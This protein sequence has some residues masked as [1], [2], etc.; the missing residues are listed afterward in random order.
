M[1]NA[2]KYIFYIYLEHELPNICGYKPTRAAF[3]RGRDAG[4]KQKSVGSGSIR[5]VS[6]PL[7]RRS[8]TIP[9]EVI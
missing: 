2:S 8:R 5:S 4:R 1:S 9:T 6:D 7:V 3:R